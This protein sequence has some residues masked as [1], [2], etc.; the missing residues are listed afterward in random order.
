MTDSPFTPL[1]LR[2]TEIP[3]RVMVSPM[4]Q[5]SAEDGFATE[6]H[7]V[8]LGSRAVGGAGVVMAE[9]TAVSPTG[10]ISPGDLG[11]WSAD[12]ADALSNTVEFVREQG[13][14]PGI[15]LAHA[16]RKASV[17]RPWDGG[18]PI[19][20][21]AGGWETLAPSANPYPHP[22][23]DTVPT[24]AMTRD[25]LDRVTAQFRLAAERARDAGFGIAEI[26]GAHG[27]LLHEFLSPVTNDRDDEYGGSFENRARFPLE[28]VEAVR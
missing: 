9:A 28:V 11:I 18:G 25:D 17:E 27:Y 20:E 24:R 2:G 19:P 8:H 14:V 23:G 3:N 26:H 16:G 1:R 13:A 12:R 22:E 6:W 4:C 10:R 5:Y 15:Q 21:E 7:R